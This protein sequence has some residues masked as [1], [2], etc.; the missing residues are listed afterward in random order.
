MEKD[1]PNEITEVDA[2]RLEAVELRVQLAV[3][4]RT[5]LHEY[6]S[7]HYEMGKD[8]RLDGRKIIRPTALQA[9]GE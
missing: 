2:L 5:Y 9:V 4:A 3:Q 1:L 6:V 8:D 7:R